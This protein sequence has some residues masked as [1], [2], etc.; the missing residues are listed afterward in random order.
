MILNGKLNLLRLKMAGPVR[1]FTSKYIRTILHEKPHFQ[2]MLW[3][4]SV[5]YLYMV[6]M[7]QSFVIYC[8][9]YK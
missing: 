8:K 3:I 4:I 6:K 9:N 1:A 7:M 2:P 5:D